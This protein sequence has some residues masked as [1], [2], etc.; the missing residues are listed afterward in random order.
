MLAQTGK[1]NTDKSL[2]EPAK[3][4]AVAVHICILFGMKGQGLRSPAGQGVFVLLSYG[5]LAITGLWAHIYAS[6]L[7][8]EK[9]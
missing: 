9:H 8:Q 7:G 5:M 1:K 3:W 4:P 6:D 2:Y